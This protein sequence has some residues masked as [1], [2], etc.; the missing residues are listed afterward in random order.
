MEFRI[1]GPLEIVDD[2][3][4]LALRGSKKRALLTI[5]LLHANE[6]V[7]RERLLDDLWGEDKPETATTALHGYVSQLRKVLEPNGDRDPRVLVTRAPGYELTIDA[8]SIDLKCFERLAERGKRALAADDAETAATT[9]GEALALWR[10]QPLAEFGSSPF[11]LVEVLRLEELRLSTN[12]DRIEA[13]LALGR[14]ASL[15]GELETL[16]AGHPYRERLCGYLMLALYRSGRQAEALDVYQRTRRAL[17]EELGIEPGTRLQQLERAILNHEPSLELPTDARGEPGQPETVGVEA[18]TRHRSRQWRALPV[19]A[20]AVIAVALSL[21]FALRKEPVSMLLEPNS[22]GFIDAESGRVT[23]SFSVGLEPR[24]LTAA[25]DSVWVANYREQTVTRIDRLSGRKATI[26]VRGHPTGI[27]S[28]R[29]MVWVWTLERMLVE[30]DPRFNVVTR[31]TSLATAT[32]PVPTAAVAEGTRRAGQS[33]GRIVSGGGFLWVAMP[34]T[35]VLRIRPT[36]AEHPLPSLPDDG[37]EGAAIAYHGALAWVGG[38][39]NVYP[40]QA[41][42]GRDG[43]AIHVG[44]ARDLVFGAGSLWV[45]SG[46]LGDQRVATAL[47]RVDLEG[48]LVRQTIDVGSSPAAVTFAR[49]S[50]WVARGDDV[51]RVDPADSAIVATIPLGATPTALAPAT[52]GIWVAVR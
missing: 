52:D 21:A 40:I 23:R 18:R 50:V 5:L 13:D 46:G 47:R 10:G 49:G 27:T 39:D 36:D 29:G 41:A 37:V 3:R 17:V 48:R 45:L 16:L 30:I 25:I 26:P 43:S 7:S 33:R 15:I 9:L 42:T 2:G 11:A 12:E 51:L 34:P 31:S 1:L 19:V 8:E 32:A 4:T 14:H 44:P 28:F 35:T 24:S 22:V 38:Y 6:V 20:L